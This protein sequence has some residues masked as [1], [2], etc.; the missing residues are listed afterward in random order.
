MVIY[1]GKDG[2]LFIGEW[3]FERGLLFIYLC[4]HI[5]ERLEIRLLYSIWEGMTIDL[6]KN[7]KYLP[8]YLNRNDHLVIYL[9]GD[10]HQ[11]IYLLENGCLGGDYYSF[12]FMYNIWERLVIYL[13]INLGGNDS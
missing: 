12:D 13:P 5:W 10:G 8:F 2:H 1:L 6:Y 7:N 3:L 4:P 9:G 11:F